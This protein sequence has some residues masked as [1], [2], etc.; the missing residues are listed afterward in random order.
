MENEENLTPNTGPARDVELVGSKR[1]RQP[2]GAPSKILRK[3]TGGS[4][5]E[6][7]SMEPHVN[8]NEIN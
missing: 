7:E 2:T 6:T 3:V 8:R 5:L 4:E 1:P